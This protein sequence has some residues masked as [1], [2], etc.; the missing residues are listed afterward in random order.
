LTGPRTILSLPL[1]DIGDLP[2]EQ[3]VGLIDDDAVTCLKARLAIEG[4]ETPIWVRRN[5]NAAKL[6]W[7]VIA[8]RHRLRAARALGWTAIDAEQ[9]ADAGSDAAEL[10]RL[11]LAENLDRRVLRPIE[12]ACFIMERWREA[13]TTLEPSAPT[14]QQSL[15]S[16]A[17][18][19]VSATVADTS[20]TALATV[21]NAEAIDAAT[22]EASGIAGRT[23]RRYRQLYD[24]IVTGL[25]EQFAELNAHPLGESL[26]AM[27]KL[28]G[29]G[30]DARPK[31]AALLRSRLDWPN[32]KAVFVK[33]GIEAS[34][35]NRVDPDKP[36][37]TF[38]TALGKMKGPRRRVTLLA[39]AA[40]L[41]PSDVLSMVEVF[42]KRRIIS[43]S[44]KIA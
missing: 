42:K 23:V 17:R 19:S 18:W 28:A 20:K 24:A 8:G 31:V 36:D 34:N 41:T 38:M 9:R 27:E 6:P 29:L 35:G 11:Q 39:M 2:D 7:S 33:A 32:I 44:V 26:K 43:D 13:A 37:I 1:A 30:P 40:D 10:R 5:G 12:R 21:A 22:A 16:R 4:L 25:P 3:C 14:N 15:A